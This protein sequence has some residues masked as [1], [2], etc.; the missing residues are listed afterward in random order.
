MRSAL[1]NRLLQA[2]LR[3]LEFRCGL[4]TEPPSNDDLKLLRSSAQEES[5]A[6]IPLDELA[7]CIVRRELQRE[8]ARQTNAL[9]TGS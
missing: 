9:R 5:E 4:A 3:V 6:R 7:Q 1:S 8:R 2:A